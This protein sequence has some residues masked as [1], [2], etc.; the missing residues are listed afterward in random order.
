MR[1]QPQGAGPCRSPRRGTL[2]GALLALCA[3][4]SPAWAADQA[5]APDHRL[6]AA[7]A[8]AA[9]V[10]DLP[11]RYHEPTVASARDGTGA[12][13]PASDALGDLSRIILALL[14]VV[15]IIF[16]LRWLAR[17]LSLVPP[18]GRTGRGV[19][20]LSRTVISPKQHVLLLQVG[21]RVVVVGDAGAAGM[22]ALCEIT[23]PDEVAAL[24]GDVKAAAAGAPP[25][26]SFSTLFGR[27][28]EPF[29]TADEL[30]A[31]GDVPAVGPAESAVPPDVVGLLA[32]VRGLR[33]QF[34]R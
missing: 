34:D 10:E 32:K 19:R 26:R 15:G 30:P 18:V 3:L 33:Q 14:V 4:A 1:P 22:R 27:A 6:G 12:V 2:I 9:N 7:P 8:A 21:R 28:A 5:A 31:D 23:D 25:A 11:V 16:A 29:D 13:A 20:L 24:L 17:R